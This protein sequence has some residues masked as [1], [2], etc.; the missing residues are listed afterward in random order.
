MDTNPSNLDDS[1]DFAE[2]FGRL[3][4]GLPLILGL[5][6][7]GLALGIIISLVVTTKQDA[8]ST[9]RVTFGFPGFEH[10]T[11]PNGSKF[12]P[13]D[14]RAPDVVNEAIKR[15]GPQGETSDLATKIRGAIGISGFVSPAIIK[16]RDRLRA[17][18][19]TLPAYIPDEY[20]ISLSLPRNFSLDVR[21]RELLLAEIINAYLEKFRRTYV[22]LPPEFG[23]AF[24]SLKNADF[25]EYELILT[26]ETQSLAAFLEQQI[27]L[28][29]Q[30]RSPNNNLSFQDLLKQTELFTQIRLNNVLGSI[31]IN[32]L[33]KDR[34][35]AL[36]KMDYYMRTLE[37]QEQRLKEEEAV[38]TNLLA[39][40]QERGQ[41]YVLGVKSQAVQARPETPLLDQ[42]LIDSLL[43][44]DSYNFLV[45]KALDAGLAVK[46]VQSEIAQL[47]DRRKRMESFTKGE[48]KNQAAAI[49]S[50][51][52]ALAGLESTYHD[53]LGKVR[54]TLEDYSRQEY[55]DAVRISMQAKTNSFSMSL[56]FGA[57]IGGGTG[58]ALGLGLSLLKAEGQAARRNLILET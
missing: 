53:L 58:F 49:A 44:N 41:G 54:T 32:G 24:S 37:D 29:K 22:A 21:Q 16:E 35:A 48:S 14:V 43:A 18:G 8:V 45:H 33:S 42:G 26:K 30:Y 17:A 1:I 10:G 6:F 12:Q 20:E 46:R 3:R 5:A 36:V 47:Q 9:L 11:Y 52:E 34:E 57:I 39:K 56:L 7:T 31:Y 15:L 13:D 51:Q 25:V 2:L 38:V 27:K 50:T 40:T 23:N 28:A 19:Q 4:R 55:A